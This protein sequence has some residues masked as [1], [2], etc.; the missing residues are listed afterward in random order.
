M[1]ADA[2][3]AAVQDE[4]DMQ[5]MPGEATIPENVGDVSAGSPVRSVHPLFRK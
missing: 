5:E 1:E 3:A 4:K 2:L